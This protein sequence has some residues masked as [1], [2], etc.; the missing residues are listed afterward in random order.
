MSDEYVV[1]IS[2]SYN[3]NAYYSTVVVVVVVVVVDMVV[4]AIVLKHLS[5]SF[6]AATTGLS[7]DPLSSS[8]VPSTLLLAF[9]GSQDNGTLRIYTVQ[10]TE[11]F[12]SENYS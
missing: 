8:S 9:D 12:R 4:G 2:F 5:L 6:S 7:A 1:M 11:G 3:Q 10:K